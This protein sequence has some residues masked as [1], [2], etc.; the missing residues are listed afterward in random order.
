MAGEAQNQ[1]IE[2]AVPF[3]R[4]WQDVRA[5]GDIQFTAAPPTAPEKITETP[6]WWLDAIKW[7]S[8]LFSGLPNVGPVLQI[9]MW[10][11]LA[12]GLLAVLWMISSRYWERR[13][14]QGK[15]EEDWQPDAAVARRLLAEA[16]ALAAKGE[17]DEA[18]HLLLHH[19][20]EDIE[21]RRPD[22]LFPSHTAREIGNIDSL[23][24]TARAMFTVIAGHVERAIFAAAPIDQDAWLA[25]RDAYRTFS[26]AD[27]WRVTMPSAQAGR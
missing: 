5:D 19:V 27:S 8:E 23:P 6:Q 14:S 3:E 4:A 20:I 17:Y 15:P 21:K 9:I 7:L 16:E 2:K 22:L 12:I 11:L 24:H 25:S 13:R 26:L 18:T 1:A 10:L